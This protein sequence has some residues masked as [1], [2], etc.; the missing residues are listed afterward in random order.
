MT[1]SNIDSEPLR[2]SLIQGISKA[3]R[4]RTDEAEGRIVAVPVASLLQGD[5][6]RLEGEDKAH[7]ARLAAIDGPL[8]PLLVDQC[9]MRVIDGMHRLLAALLK[10]QQT[11]EVRFF[12]GSQADAFLRAVEANVTHGLPLSKADRRAAAE[13]IVM[14]HPQLSDRAI[15][16]LAGLG[17]KT[18]A[19][20]RQRLTLVAQ[21]PNARVGIDGKTRPL[22]SREGRQ[23]AA[24]L[25]I[26]HPRTSLREVARH[27][28]ISAAT[29]SDVRKRLE[30]GE[31]PAPPRSDSTSRTKPSESSDS[32][33]QGRQNVGSARRP[34]AQAPG[35]SSVLVPRTLFDDPSLR[36][37]EQGRR[38]LRWLQHSPGDPQERSGVVAAIPPH[39]A[40]LVV[41]LARHNSQAWLDFAQELDGR[42]RII[43]PWASDRR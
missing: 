38:L 7:V 18:I 22:N 37:N 35:Q 5:S 10:G 26:E 11:I 17:T 30:R 34:H 12:N 6:P 42:A 29:A 2:L 33:T 40:A 13:R 39:C 23:L 36:Y 9:S 3:S 24:E 14:S 15:A 19:G 1:V 4:T 21:Q 41:R 20:I 31:E 32:K 27:A 25:L 16:Q 8:P 28:G 43:D